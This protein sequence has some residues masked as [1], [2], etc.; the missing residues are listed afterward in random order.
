MCKNN[1][2]NLTLDECY[3]S[4]CALLFNWEAFKTLRG[5]LLAWDFLFVYLSDYRRAMYLGSGKV[6][7]HGLA[8]SV[9]QT[10]FALS[11]KSLSKDL[12]KIDFL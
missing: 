10:S 9:S 4:V 2:P 12:V 3:K 5:G 8:P 7:D 11:D 6:R 1:S